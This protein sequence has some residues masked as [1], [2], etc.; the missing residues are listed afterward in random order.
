VRASRARIAE[1]DDAAR[2]QL[3]R[4]LHDGVQQRLVTLSMTLVSTLRQLGDLPGTSDFQATLAQAGDP[5]D[6]GALLSCG[7]GDHRPTVLGR[8][9]DAVAA[10]ALQKRRAP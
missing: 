6:T 8:R 4:D 3:E 5:G 10:L 7:A 2:R 9:V 1:A